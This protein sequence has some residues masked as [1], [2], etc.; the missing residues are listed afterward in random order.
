M[1]VIITNLSTSF[2]ISPDLENDIYSINGG[3]PY[4][5]P[6]KCKN[7]EYKKLTQYSYVQFLRAVREGYS[8]ILLNYTPIVGQILNEMHNGKRKPNA[9]DWQILTF[10]HNDKALKNT[11]ILVTTDTPIDPQILLREKYNDL[12][13][14][15]VYPFIK[16]YEIPYNYEITAYSLKN[17]C[18]P[19]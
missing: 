10:F 7:N 11:G 8:I 12:Q 6:E 16:K 18:F 2:T 3:M 15:S 19:V 9:S 17:L 5:P 14:M 4:C 13:S 1:V